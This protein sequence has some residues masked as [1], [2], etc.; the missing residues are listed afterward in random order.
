[1]VNHWDLGI[2]MGKEKSAAFY[3][4]EEPSTLIK[5]PQNFPLNSIH[6]N[7]CVT[8]QSQFNLDL[9]YRLLVKNK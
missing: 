5:N 8:A 4:T 9:S 6:P 3:C 1:M 2:W 7:N